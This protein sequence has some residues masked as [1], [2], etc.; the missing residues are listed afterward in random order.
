MKRPILIDLFCGAGGAGMGYYR[1]GFDV[2]GIDYKLQKNYPFP[3]IQWNL[4]R[5]IP[6][7]LIWQQWGILPFDV[8]AYHASPPCQIHSQL[9]N[10]HKGNSDYQVRHIDLIPQTRDLLKPTEKPYVIENVIGARRSLINPIMLCG[11]QFDLKVYRH[12][13]FE[14]SFSV[15]VPIHI[16]HDDKTPRAGGGVSPKGFVTVCGH[17]GVKYLPEDFKGGFKEYA[18]MAMGIPWMSRA[19]LSQAIPPA[20]TE[21]IGKQFIDQLKR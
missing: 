12:R 13:L 15:S 11:K 9:G 2:Y 3:F 21:F 20:Y 17:G 16:K 10:I 6:W 7:P 5:G 19:E 14:C 4:Q 18:R 8:D 1:A